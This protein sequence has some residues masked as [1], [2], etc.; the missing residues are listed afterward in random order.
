MKKILLFLTF[1][2]FTIISICQAQTLWHCSTTSNSSSL[3]SV[4]FG[5]SKSANSTNYCNKQIRIY[6]HVVRSSS[7]T[8]GLT[9]S[10]I[11]QLVSNLNAD[12][13]T[14]GI[15][16]VEQGRDYIDNNNYYNGSYDDA[17]FSS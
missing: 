13:S 17:K 10:Q 5:Q 16:F 4:D 11:S 7:G 14:M 3:T 6:F 1:N 9:S 2:I 15:S 12:Y 8:G